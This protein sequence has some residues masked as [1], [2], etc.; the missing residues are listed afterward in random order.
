MQVFRK[1]HGKA[2]LLSRV[3]VG[4]RGGC[5]GHQCV[6]GGFHKSGV[7]LRKVTGL[8]PTLPN[9]NIMPVIGLT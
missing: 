1:K 4:T 8:R 3:D 6:V 5:R 7:R 2:K 9:S